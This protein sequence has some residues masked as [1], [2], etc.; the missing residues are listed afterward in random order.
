MAKKRTNK[1]KIAIEIGAGLA[2]AGAA[3]AVG[4]YFYASKSAKKHRK[5]AA[6][7]ANNLKKDVIREARRLEK[8][9]PKKL[10]QVIDTVVSSYQGLRSVNKA[11]LKR[12]AS[13]LK[14][15]LTLVA[16]E[17]KKTARANASRAKTVGTHVLARSKKT[18][19]KIVRKVKK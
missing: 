18:I 6:K 11:D 1:R 10:E 12:A 16:K 14:S 15:N 5:V 4:Y 3:A 13:E 8:I 9:D 7:W 17:A 19:K 2:A